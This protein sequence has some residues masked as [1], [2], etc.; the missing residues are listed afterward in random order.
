MTQSEFCKAVIRA[1][2]ND[3]PPIL[4]PLNDL[5]DLLVICNAGGLE[6]AFQDDPTAMWDTIMNTREMMSRLHSALE[7]YSRSLPVA[8]LIEQGEITYDEE[9]PF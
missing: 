4:W 1:L 8:I 9:I 7:Q 5:R 2:T 3:N 6:E